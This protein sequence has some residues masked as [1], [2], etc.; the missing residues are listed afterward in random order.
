M[1]DSLSAPIHYPFNP[2]GLINN[3]HKIMLGRID[4]AL[5]RCFNRTCQR[6]C[7]LLF[8]G[9][10]S[11]IP[12][13]HSQIANTKARFMHKNFIAGEWVDSESVIQNI[14]P[15]DTNDIIGEY[16]QATSVQLESAI[17]AAI[18]ARKACREMSL[19]ARQAALM[20]IGNELLARQDELGELL[21]R[22]EGKTLAEGIGEVNRSGKHFIFYAA[23]VLRQMGQTADSVRAGI[24]IDVRREPMGVVAVISP[25]NFPMAI[26]A[27]KIGPA[28]AYGNAVLFKPAN[29]TPGSA[30]ALMGIISRSGLPD[31]AVQ[32]LM[33]SGGKIGDALARDPRVDAVTFTG[34]LEVGK[35]VAVATASHLGKYQLELGSKN[36]LLVM[37]DANLDAAAAAAIAGAYFGTGQKCTCSSRLIVHSAVHDQFVD[38]MKT[39]MAA[40]KIGHALDEG[41]NIGPCVSAGQL[42]ANLDWIE[43]AKIEGADIAVGGGTVECR[44]PGH[45]MA[46]TLLTNTTNDMSFNREEMFAPTAAVIKVDSYDEGLATANDTHYGLS[47]GIFT[48]SLARATHFRRHIET[49]VVTINLPT[50]GMD[51]HVPFGGRK[52]SSSGPRE[53]GSAAMEFFTQMK[54]SYTLAGAPE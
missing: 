19:E 10:T 37:D 12:T 27:W 38:L 22:E 35:Q 2:A 34:S 5:R 28:L 16:A 21:A 46:P 36:A 31:N 52:M 32:L 44:T 51:Y 17:Q 42:A 3:P 18:A 40:I 50:G 39:K 43:K 33:G 30:H 9:K 7:F 48:Q 6:I 54:T 8:I 1:A 11:A 13:S 25:W 24:E 53:Q 4:F 20:F 49:G 47:A 23:E 45:Y 26:P 29:L 14:N 41:V 15:S